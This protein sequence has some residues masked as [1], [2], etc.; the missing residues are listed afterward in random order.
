MLDVHIDEFFNDCTVALLMGL[1]SFPA[2]KTLFV[3]DIAGPDDMDEFGLHSARH[4]AALGA[5]CWLK[6]E[7]FVRFGA[8]D[9][10]ESVDNFVLTSKAFSRLLALE[11]IAN[12]PVFQ[13]LESARMEQ[14]S[15]RVSFLLRTYLIK[16]S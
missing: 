16:E 14:D 12:Q 7:G 2:A 4:I 3:E 1:Q 10:Q 13:I 11:P 5:L 8:M 15:T 9:R 6:D